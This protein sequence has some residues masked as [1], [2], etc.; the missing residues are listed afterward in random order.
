[1]EV[2]A[3]KGA[4]L[5]GSIPSLLVVQIGGESNADI[6]EVQ[7]MRKENTIRKYMPVYQAAPQGIRQIQQGSEKQKFL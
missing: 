1:M 6:Q 4:A 2:R 7:Q 5:L 3:A